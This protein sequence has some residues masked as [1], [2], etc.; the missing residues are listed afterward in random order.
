MNMT[1]CLTGDSAAV[2]SF[3]DRFDVSLSVPSFLPFLTTVT[4]DLFDRL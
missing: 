2:Q 1:Q 3:L 4:A